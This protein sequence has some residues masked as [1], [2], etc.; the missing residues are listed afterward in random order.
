MKALPFSATEDAAATAGPRRISGL[1]GLI[2]ERL[3]RSIRGRLKDRHLSEHYIRLFEEKEYSDWFWI[4]E[5]L[6]KWIRSSIHACLATGD[7]ELRTRVEDGLRRLY[8][9]QEESGY[10]NM[11]AAKRRKPVRGMELYESYFTLHA[12]ISAYRHLDEDRA[13]LAAR[14]LA[15]FFLRLYGSG[16]GK[17]P[18]TASAPGTGHQGHWGTEGTLIIHPVLRLY[19]LTGEEHYLRWS[20]DIVDHWDEW[21]ARPPGGA[22][23]AAAAGTA[24]AA[25]AD[26][27]GCAY[28]TGLERIARGEMG[29][30]DLHPAYVHAHTLHM[31]L[32]GLCELYR[33]TGRAEYLEIVESVVRHIGETQVTLTG[34]MGD[35]EEY[36][37]PASYCPGSTVEVCPMSSWMLLNAEL[38]RIT[39]SL[40]YFD[41]VERTLYNHFLAAQFGRGDDWSYFTPYVGRGSPRGYGDRYYGPSHCCNSSGH[42]LLSMLPGMTYGVREAGIDVLLFETSI[43]DHRL[44][45]GNHVRLTQRTAFPESGEVHLRVEVAAPERFRLAIRKPAWCS[46]AAVCVNGRPEAVHPAGGALSLSRRWE[47]GDRVDIELDMRPRIT[48][49]ENAASLTRGPVVYACFSELQPQ[50]VSPQ[51]V[52]AFDADSL[53]P[54]ETPKGCVG[55]AFRGKALIQGCRAPLFE[56]ESANARLAPDRKDWVLLVPFFNRGES[57]GDHSIFFDCR[58]A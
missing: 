39:G 42:M 6:G 24:G 55:P 54:T 40:G 5:Q 20:Q 31:N 34:G 23:A 49:F 56:T 21:G 18:M 41:A 38:Y 3:A 33:S 10:L 11:A 48:R 17:I 46:R 36:K 57:G 51:S 27:G 53:E 28:W 37:D 14:R 1:G 35:Y 25:G 22:A 26:H 15:D 8:A 16:P 2:G 12:L 7:A 45:S 52:R 19:Q 4:G 30:A 29:V 43:L 44:A 47:E 32:L 50:P 9:C 58:N 13:L